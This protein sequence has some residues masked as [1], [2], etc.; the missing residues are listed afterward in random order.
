LSHAV[1]LMRN[2]L[3]TDPG[4]AIYRRR[5]AMMQ[6]QWAAVLR[7]SGRISEAISHNER[8]L[9]LAQALH[10]DAPGSAEYRVDVGVIE[11]NVSEGLLAAG[12]AAAALRHATQAEN[13]LCQNAPVPADPFTAA[14]CGRSLLAA[15]NSA[16]ALNEPLEAVQSFHE[17]E[18]IASTRSQ[19]EPLNA[20]FRS[21]W[22]RSEAALAAG[23]AKVAD[24]PNASAMYEAALKNWSLLRNANSLSAED[25]HRAEEATRAFAAFDSR[26]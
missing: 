23:L 1:D 14:N 15:G 19:L 3:N 11:R 9:S 2:L 12:D 18:I 16:L 20:I 7:G 6:S 4:N 22:A 8:A 21:D 24:D 26:R 10:H 5:E 25:A 13:I 17:A